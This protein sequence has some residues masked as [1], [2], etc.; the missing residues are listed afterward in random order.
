MSLK[1]QPLR[2]TQNEIRILELQASQ[3]VAAPLRCRLRH[4]PLETAAFTALSYVWGQQDTD[5]H[6]LEIE[7]HSE[8]PVSVSNITIG[9]SLGSALR[10][11]RDSDSVKMIWADAV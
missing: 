3:D 11:L 8:G 2:K 5:R 9:E 1:Y 4:V 6:D 7:Y 10:R